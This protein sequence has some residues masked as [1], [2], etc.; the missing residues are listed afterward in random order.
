METTPGYGK[1]P[2]MGSKAEVHHVLPWEFKQAGSSKNNPE[3]VGFTELGFDVN[4]LQYG[5]WAEKILHKKIHNSGL[6][7]LR[8]SNYWKGIL[9][10]I[11]DDMLVSDARQIVEQILTNFEILDVFAPNGIYPLRF[12]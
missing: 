12:Q 7:H 2:G 9:S 8:Y 11:T 4:D 5:Q 6:P 3:L 1:P 10:P